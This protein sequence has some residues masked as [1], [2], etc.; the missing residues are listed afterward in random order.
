M[1]TSPF[2]LVTATINLQLPPAVVQDVNTHWLS[3]VT[4]QIGV[5]AS[6]VAATDTTITLA[7]EPSG[8][9][10]GQTVL[11]DSEPMSVTATNGAVLTVSRVATAFPFMMGLP[12]P[13]T[14]THAQGLPVQT[15]QWSDP[16]TVIAQEALRPWAQQIVTNLGAKSATFGSVASGSLTA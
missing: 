4:G 9:S 10:V 12:V 8:L 5:L 3:E 1:S 13:P 11:C 2:A 6:A 16:W 7:A 14:T 15:L